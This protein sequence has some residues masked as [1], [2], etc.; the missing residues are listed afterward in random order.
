MTDAEHPPACAHCRG[1]EDSRFTTPITMAFQPIVD[2][3]DRR[4]WA[5]EALVRGTDG[6]GAAAILGMVD[7]AS[8]YSF[9]QKCRTT[10]IEVASRTG[11]PDALSI[12]FMPNAV[13]EPQ[14]C[15]RTTLM[16][17]E[18]NEFD[19]SRLIFELTETEIVRDPLHLRKIVTA[20]RRFGFRTAID[21]FGAGFAGLGLLIDMQPDIIKIDRK[22]IAGIDAEPVRQAVLAGI[23][24]TAGRL[25]ISIVAEG[26][27]RLEEARWLAAHGI[28]LMQ[29]Y[30]F[31]RPVFEGH[32]AAGDINWPDLGE[33]ATPSAA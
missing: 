25:G 7:D 13:Y 20:Y 15:I 30:L 14:A 4:I 17:A 24:E 5:Q 19:L 32:V 16:A 9:D 27:E 29:G 33:V 11:L 26:I 10:A 3:V 2:V 22:L 8:R 6:A 28:R 31:A 18:R 1:R 21:D 12:N 23:A